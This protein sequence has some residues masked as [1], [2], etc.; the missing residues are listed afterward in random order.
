MN[1]MFRSVAVALL[2]A[3]A[4]SAAHAQSPENVAVVINDASPDSQRIGEHY[5]RTRGLP[6]SNVLRIRTTTDDAIERHAYSSTIERPLAAA[7]G[8][9]GLQ[10]RLLYI[11]LTKGVPLRIVGT[12]GLKGT[13]ASVDSELTL[14]YRRLTGQPVAAPGYVENPYFL[15]TRPIAEARRFSHRE[16][17]IF[18][19][20]RLDAFTTDQALALVDRARSPLTEGRIVLDQRAA[21]GGPQSA[22]EWLERAARRLDEQGHGQRV[23]L[24]STPKAAQPVDRVLGYYAWGAADPERRQRSTG[25]K[26]VP[27]SIAATLGSFDARTFRAPSDE[28]QPTNSADKAAW[29]EGSGDS[30]IGDLIREGAT[31]VSGQV[32][33]AFVLGAVRPEILFPAYV[34]GF[35]LA[36]AFYLATPA[37]SW[38]TVIV[39]DPLGGPFGRA[40]LTQADLEEP[41]DAATGL[42]GLFAK[43][44]V[45]AIAALNPDVPET[46][47]AP[48]VRAMTLLDNENRPAAAGAL[49]AAV[50]VSPKVP[51]WLVFL[52]A[53]Q[54]LTGDYGGAITTYRSALD[55]QPA[56]VVALNNLA[57]ALAVHLGVPAE[58]LPLA[59]RAAALAPRVGTILDTLAWIEHLLGNDVEA[60]RLLETA[61]SLDP[62]IAEIHLHAAVVFAAVGREDRA[63][64]ALREAIRL[65][66]ALESNEDLQRLKRTLTP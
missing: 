9:A 21:A 46:A 38:Q 30:L 8:R 56:N 16:H 34:A 63:K 61:I 14:L 47:I 7:I 10:D 55:L 57:Y 37:L 6:P 19:V 44:R 11:V 35:N 54:E 2:L 52:G 33:E 42:P 40:P 43:R 25:M 12:T 3:V 17:D 64:Q 50:K 4:A 28:W 26:F 15:G 23:L 60:A 48:F 27:G 45:A 13:Q 18:L 20:T 58:A 41:A 66:A 65:D 31:G 32:S 59:R 51:N 49:A 39:G 36:E 22:D 1:H 29:F 24:E 5:A 62:S 53:Q